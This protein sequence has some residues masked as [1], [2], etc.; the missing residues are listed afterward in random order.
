M[1]KHTIQLLLVACLI[2]GTSWAA[3]EPF[4]GKWKA[5]PSNS[6]L[7][8]EMK[9]EPA[10]SLRYGFVFAP[11]ASETIVVDG[12]D[13]PGIFGTTLSVAVEG[14]D[15]W[16]V[17]R[18]KDG[19]ML[20]LAIWKLSPDGNTLSDDFTGYPPGGS[21]FSELN[22]YKRTA[23]D[24]GFSGTWDRVREKVGPASELTIEPYEGD[25]LSITDSAES[26]TKNMK[27]DGKD[28]PVEGPK[29]APGGVSAGVRANERKLE[30]IDRINGKITD[31]QQM[32]LSPDL[33]TLTMTIRPLGRSEPNIL[34]FN[35]E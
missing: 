22:V 9:V 28:Y 3:S 14:P 30:L 11:G 18:K 5:D 19:H 20:L 33:K 1:L 21:K 15:T 23:G 35:R 6:K 17:V 4:A 8:D 2:S 27:F 25:G 16:K 12:S 26:V 10:G 13:Q 34:V 24:S 31:T 32:E 29:A 7:I